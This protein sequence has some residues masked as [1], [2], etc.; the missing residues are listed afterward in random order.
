[1]EKKISARASDRG[2]FSGN[3]PRISYATLFLF[4]LFFINIIY[5]IIHIYL[6]DSI[7]ENALCDELS[8]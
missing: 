4:P 8:T 5:T 6:K 3:L 7:T 1:M 2:Y